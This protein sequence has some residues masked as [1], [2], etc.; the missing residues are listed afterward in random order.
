MIHTI[1]SRHDSLRNTKNVL[2]S[3]TYMLHSEKKQSNQANV[4]NDPPNQQNP[5]LQYFK[6]LVREIRCTRRPVALDRFD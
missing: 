5:I 1:D 3:L 6:R 2:E 4:E